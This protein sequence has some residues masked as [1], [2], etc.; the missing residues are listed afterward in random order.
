MV[1]IKAGAL[2]D[3]VRDIFTKAGCSAA[4]GERIGKYL[5][6]GQPHRPRQPRRR[7]R[8]ALP[9]VEAGRRRPR[10]P[11]GRGRHRDAGAGGG[12]RP[13]RLRPDGGAAGGRNRHR[14]VPARAWRWWRCA[15]PAISAGSATGR[16][17]PPRRASSRS[18]SSTPRAAC[19]WRRS[20]APSGA[21]RP[22]PICVGIPR[23]GERADRARLRHL[24]GRRGQGV[25]RQPGRQEASRRRADRPRRRA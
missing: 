25:G 4:E 12:R 14:Q 22:R 2:A 17:W 7:A 18:T 10:R 20:A 5:V 16:R 19:W 13:V 9:A 11:Q 8:A 3:L 24:G 23:P 1:T 15:T 21:C 6:G